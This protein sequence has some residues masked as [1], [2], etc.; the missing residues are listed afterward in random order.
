MPEGTIL[1]CRHPAALVGGNTEISPRITDVI[2]GALAG[3]LPERVPASQG[4]TGIDPRF[5]I[6]DEMTAD[7][8]L[9]DAVAEAVEPNALVEL[10]VADLSGSR[11]TEV[12]V[13]RMAEEEETKAVGSTG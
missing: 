10:S 9:E 5:V 7:L 6:A 4:G 12:R 13:V 8:L 2:F 11:I 1:N 3:A